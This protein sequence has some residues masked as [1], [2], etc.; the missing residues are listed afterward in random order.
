[1]ILR[2]DDPLLVYVLKYFGSCQAIIDTDEDGNTYLVNTWY[3]VGFAHWYE[4]ILKSIPFKK[5]D[6]DKHERLQELLTEMNLNKESFWGLILYLYDYTIDACKNLLAPQKTHKEIYNELCTFLEQNPHI[7]SLTFKT[8]NRKTYTLSDK[9]ILDFLAIYLQ[10][11]KMSDLQKRRYHNELR[12]L[13]IAEK[14][15]SRRKVSYFFAQQLSQFLQIEGISTIK[16]RRKATISNKEKELI[17]CLLYVCKFADNPENYLDL[18][19]YNRLMK[20]YKGLSMNVSN[21]Y[22]LEIPLDWRLE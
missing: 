13:S 10:E 14:A 5:S 17:L 12:P 9:L 4:D 18:G 15:D 11:E 7:E 6:Y 19:Y 22:E 21:K 16:R 20:D 2:I 1:M 8:T 3:P